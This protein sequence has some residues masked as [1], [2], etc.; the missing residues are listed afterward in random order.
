MR[1]RQIVQKML[2]YSLI[3]RVGLVR[4]FAVRR[5]LSHTKPNLLFQEVKP[6]TFK[7]VN[8]ISSGGKP[9]QQSTGIRLLISKYGYSAIGIYF[10]LSV[11]DMGITFLM[12]HSLGQDKI[13][14]LE[15]GVKDYFGWS[16]E[17]SKTASSPSEGRI[18]NNEKVAESKENNSWTT[19]LTEFGI[20]FAIHKT[21]IIF[22][23]PLTMAI[24]PPI[25]KALQRYGF[26]VGNAVTTT[27]TIGTKSTG[28]QRFGSWFF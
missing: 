21:L 11:I 5:M 7:H 24:T 12:V 3:P 20:A 2:R 10:G 16:T 8:S 27:R 15:H 4:P 22:R 19:L 13:L 25:V 17:E 28:T 26:N 14:E 1:N 6:R 9:Q 18:H 23:V